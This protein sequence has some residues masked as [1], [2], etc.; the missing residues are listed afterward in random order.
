[1]KQNKPSSHNEAFSPL[2]SHWMNEEFHVS[3]SELK[4]L[5]SDCEQA[6]TR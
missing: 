1:M 4:S 3:M 5:P 2:L 6:S